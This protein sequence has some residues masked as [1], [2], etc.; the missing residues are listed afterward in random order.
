MANFRAIV[1]TAILGLILVGCKHSDDSIVVGCMAP[2]TGEAATYGRSTRRGVELAVEQI[3]A[4]KFLSKPLT[5]DFEDD[6]MEPREGLNAFH[7]LVDIDH[8]PVILGPFG[9]SV[10]MSCAPLA[11]S[12]KT[13]IITASATADQIADAGD[14]VFRIVPPNSKQGFDLAEFSIHKLGAKRAAILY[15][16]NDY[17][18]TLRDSFTSTFQKEGGAI[19]RSEGYPLGAVDY[20]AA[21][22]HIKPL[23]PD[24]I[25]FPLHQKE[26]ALMLRQAKELGISSAF[27]SADGA[28]TNDLISAAGGA[29]ENTYFSTMALAFGVADDQIKS[30]QQAFRE[31]FG[32]DPD[33]Y[34]AYYYELTNLLA[35]VI[36]N[37]GS[38]NEAIRQGLV[39][40]TGNNAYHG[41]TGE[42]SFDSKGEVNKNFYIYQVR[43]G[44]FEL[45]GPPL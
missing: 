35:Q 23:K 9:S 36:R 38:N 37:S 5:V 27:I 45:V 25:F 10:V 15:Q 34:A 7:K 17:G 16:T 21:L 43:N 32:E 39:S 6:R 41:I 28:Y 3:N 12:S 44:R 33:V 2:F 8:V 24:V 29:A 4:R 18:M 30:F 40:M 1:C 22:T 26:A 20:R 42:T 14:Y 11:N 19:L 31:K 13:V